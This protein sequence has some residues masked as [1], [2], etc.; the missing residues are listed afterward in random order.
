MCGVEITDKSE[1]VVKH[2]FKGDTVFLLGN[3]GSGI[4]DDHKKY[5]DHF[6]YI[7]H[8]TDC[9]GSLNVACAASIVFHHFAVWAGY[10]F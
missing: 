4:I 7:P 6:V 8:Y 10:L 2:P 3:E 5:C 1:N 9:T